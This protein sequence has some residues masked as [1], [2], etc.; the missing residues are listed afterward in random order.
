MLGSRNDIGAVMQ[1][2]DLL[3]VNSTAE[4]FG[5]VIVEAMACGTPV[6]AVSVDGIPEIIAH[7]QNGWLVPPRDEPALAAAIVHLSREAGLRRRLARQG[8]QDVK[9]FSADRYLAE[10]EGFYR[11]SGG[12]KQKA[13]EIDGTGRQ[14][15][16]AKFA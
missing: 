13:H 2:L 11:A 15:E 1:S 9:R 10:L 7:D 12:A 6:L 5:L 14:A 4:P 8:R 3:I 16:T